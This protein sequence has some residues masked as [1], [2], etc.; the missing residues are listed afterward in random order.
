MIVVPATIDQTEPEGQVVAAARIQRPRGW[1]MS[2]LRWILGVSKEC[3]LEGSQE[4]LLE[5]PLGLASQGFKR[6]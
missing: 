1:L 2:S 6:V 3:C 5:N 4:A